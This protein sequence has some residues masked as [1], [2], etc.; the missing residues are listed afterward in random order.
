MFFHDQRFLGLSEKTHDSLWSH[1]NM[2]FN[3]AAKVGIAEPKP[4]Q[5]HE[6][7]MQR[8]Q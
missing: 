8:A 7:G 5:R 4:G 3:Q 1:L 6:Q 2:K